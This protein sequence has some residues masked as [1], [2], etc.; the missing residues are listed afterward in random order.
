MLSW[1][2]YTE[3]L[4]SSPSLYTKLQQQQNANIAYNKSHKN[5]LKTVAYKN[6]MNLSN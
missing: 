5:N 6:I 3:T 2:A 4:L 1:S